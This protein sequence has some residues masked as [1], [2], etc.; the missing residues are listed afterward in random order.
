[1]KTL[2][3]ALFLVALFPCVAPAKE[4]KWSIAQADVVLV[5]DQRVSDWRAPSLKITDPKL[6]QEITGLFLYAKGRWKKG[7]ATSPSGDIRFIFYRGDQYLDAVGVGDRFL[8][9]GG[10]GNWESMQI[11]P[12]LEARLR[13]FSEKKADPA[14]TD[15]AGATPR[16]V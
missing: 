13:K 7:F 1:M 15:N 2:T 14:G 4:D 6:V 16:R 9:R 5:S 8:V 12:E 3:A 11:S 10:G